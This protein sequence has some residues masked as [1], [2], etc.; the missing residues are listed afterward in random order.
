MK[1]ITL[2]LVAAGLAASSLGAYA[3]LPTG[4]APFQVTVPN[5]APGV[6]II[7]EGLYLQP[8]ISG[9]DTTFATLGTP[10]S[11]GGTNFQTESVSPQYNFGFRVGLGYIFPNS[12]NDVQLN[13]T[14]FNHNTTD[15]AQ[16][17]AGGVNVAFS[18]NLQS[19][20]DA[21]DLD[22]GQYM[23]IG[24]R[25]QTRL[26]AG[27]RAAQ[28]QANQTNTQQIVGSPVAFNQIDNDKFEG[29]GPRLGIDAKY[30][31]FDCF[32]VVAHMASSLLV[33]TVK[34]S[35]ERYNSTGVVSSAQAF[36]NQT[37]IVPG[38]DAKL[39]VDYSIRFN[40]AATSSMNIE[41]GWQ[42]TQYVHAF[43]DGDGAGFQ[44]PYLGVNFKI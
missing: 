3:A 10:N 8:T 19:K 18:G 28:L 17:L 31:V 30:N 6:E 4:A 16:G 40:Q 7:L 9:N 42:A 34:E 41:L 15:T 32:G 37:Q 33:S 12:G 36:D 22:V 21:I 35:N 27:V 13:W 25:F 5:L 23:S 29:I 20:Y 38:F 26:F 24:T 39:G 43:Q 2:S 11:T 1:K 14:H 44:G